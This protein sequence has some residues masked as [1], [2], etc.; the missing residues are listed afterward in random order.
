MGWLQ[1]GAAARPDAVPAADAPAMIVEQLS[2]RE[3]DVLRRATAQMRELAVNRRN[4]AV[5]RARELRLL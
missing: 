4:D 2:G 1:P 3:R 5:R